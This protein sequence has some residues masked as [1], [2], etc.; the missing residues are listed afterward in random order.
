MPIHPL[1]LLVFVFLT[2]VL[3]LLFAGGLCQRELC[4]EESELKKRTALWN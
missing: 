1:G 4:R 3:V 2:A